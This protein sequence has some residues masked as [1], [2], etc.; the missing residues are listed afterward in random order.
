MTEQDHEFTTKAETTE[1]SSMNIVGKGRA[2]SKET[3][4]LIQIVQCQCG[5]E[6]IVISTTSEEMNETVNLILDK[7]N[8]FEAVQEIQREEMNPGRW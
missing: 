1:K 7:T 6:D 8:F 5:S 2:V 3:E 4:T